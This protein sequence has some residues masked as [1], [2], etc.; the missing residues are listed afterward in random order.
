MKLQ[1]YLDNIIMI[2]LAIY[3]VSGYYETPIGF[4]IGQMLLILVIALSFVNSGF[5]NLFSYPKH[6]IAYWVY[7]ALAILI[8]Q[9]DFKLSNI[10]PGGPNF[11]V[12]SVF[13]GVCIKHFEYDKL[14]RY[15]GWVFCI[16]AAVFIAQEFLYKTI[17]FR[18]CALLPISDS[19]YGGAIDYM[20]LSAL[21]MI[22]PRS[23]SIFLEPSYFA[24][25]I[26]VYMSLLLFSDDRE[27]T[28]LDKYLLLLGVLI[29]VFLRSGCGIVGLAVLVISKIISTRKQYGASRFIALLVILIPVLLYII[30]IYMS[31]DIG[32]SMMERQEEFSS[33]DSSAYT[34]IV[35]GFKIYGVLPFFNQLFG[36]SMDD[37]FAISAANGIQLEHNE[38]A[39]NGFQTVLVQNGL[40]GFIILFLFY[41]ALYKR[42]FELL[43][44]VLLLLLLCLSLMESIYLSPLMLLITVIVAGGSKRDAMMYQ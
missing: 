7:A 27:K 26:L 9:N 11:F 16:G 24:Q 32:S 5:Y 17:G 38:L 40:I 33:D 44:K 30:N 2:L 6:Y 42:S 18:F 39:T 8:L 23:P 25:Y 41:V 36:I 4:S 12:W 22:A 15:M 35:R 14:K 37:M 28:R 10:I 34:R 43:K 21:H 3:P 19:F 31:S 29:L 13:L 1:S 20:G